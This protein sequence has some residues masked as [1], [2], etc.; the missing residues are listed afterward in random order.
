MTIDDA[1]G[2]VGIGTENPGVRL[3]IRNPGFTGLDIQSE[4]SSGTIGGIRWKPILLEI[5]EQTFMD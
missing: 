2:N 3:H 4:R 5:I 1:T